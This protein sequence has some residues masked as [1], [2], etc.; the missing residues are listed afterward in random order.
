LN[1]N[2]HYVSQV[3]LRL[4]AVS[5]KLQ[6]Y[7]IKDDKWRRK[8]PRSVF[9]AFG[10]NQ[11]LV[12]GKVDNT[13]EAAF[14]KVETPLPKVFKALEEAANHASTE[15]PSAIYEN[16]CWYCAFL[17][18]I[19]PFAKAAAPA[20]FV[21]Q[22]NMDLEKGN[23]RT[24]REVLNIPDDQ[25][26]GLLKTHAAGRRFII[27]SENFL[28]LVYRIQFQRHYQLDYSMFRH[29]AAW[30]ICHSPIELPISDIA[31]VQMPIHE[32]NSVFYILPVGPRLL[33]KGQIKRGEATNSDQTSI[34]GQT[35][36]TDEANLWFDV[37]GLSA[38]T[39]LVSCQ[40][41]PDIAGIRARAKARGMR[42]QKIVDPDLAIAAGR[43]DFTASFGIK[44]VSVEE[45]RKFVTSFIQP[46]GAEA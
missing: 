24:L 30:S 23:A 29:N 14:S 37:I 25:I 42:F 1:E 33:L 5:G 45:Y 41:I 31:L 34:K 36:R 35:L 20:N 38:V 18:R 7:Q 16:L 22:I 4:F 6:S 28:Q 2:E 39:E 13:L 15:L 8:S 43:E 9:S 12:D 3:L 19:S 21:V 11:L 27:D 44:E 40:V 17:W 32:H 46:P 10:Y 26:A